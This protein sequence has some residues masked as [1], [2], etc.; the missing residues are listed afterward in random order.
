[1]GLR[2]AGGALGE[3]GLKNGARVAPGDERPVVAAGHP[4][5]QKVDRGIE[6]DGGCPR[7]DERA[8]ARIDEGAAAG[9][10]H[11]ARAGHQAGYHAALAVAEMRLAEAGKDIADGHAGGGFDFGVA[12]VER[13]AEPGGEAAADRGLAGPHQADEDDGPRA[14]ARRHA[15]GDAGRLVGAGRG[16]FHSVHARRYRGAM[17]ALTN[18]RGAGLFLAMALAAGQVPA[19]AQ[20]A[21]APKSL[22]PDD[23]DEAPT[24]ILPP[25]AAGIDQGPGVPQAPGFQ[26]LPVPAEPVEPDE[27][28]EPPPTDPFAE[29][30]GPTGQPQGAGLLDA[31][32]GGFGPD[33]FAGSDS[34]FLVTLLERIER[35]LAS[36]WAQILVQRALA[37]VAVP[38]GPHHPSDWLAARA[39]AL[40]A[41][42]AATDAHRMVARVAIDQ[43]T[44]RL[45]GAAAQAALAA[46]D[47]MALCPL[48]PT[49]RLALDT[50][51]WSLMDAMCLAI[52]GDEVG[53]TILFDR[54]RRQQG[55]DPFDIGLA[56][57][58][59]STAGAGRRGS[60][61]EWSD[62]Q[63]L[64]AFRIGLASAAGLDLPDAALGGA[65]RAQRAWL[66]RIPTVSVARRAAMAPMAAATG[67]FS[68]A[69][70]NRLLAAEVATLAAAEAPRSPGG[71]LRTAHADGD[72][73]QRIAAMRALWARGEGDPDLGYGWR[74][75]TAPAAARLAPSAAL[76]ADAADI[77]ASLNAA[78]YAASV[79]GWWQ[80]LAEA[81]GDAR[82]RLWG[83]AVAVAPA[84]PVSR[85]W[86]DRWAKEA[87][88]RRAALLSAG[89]LGLGRGAVGEAPTPIDNAWTR[90]LD[91]A[92]AGRR[93]GEVILLVAAGMQGRMADLPP[94][95]L[96]RIAA[97]L[98]AV[99]R[100]AEARL[101]VAEAIARS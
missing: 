92:L 14:P 83:H 59:A 10:Q 37:S 36:R 22:L 85:E 90:A 24:V 41:L 101:L 70:I 84:V 75:A 87:G 4:L 7:D 27:E 93:T 56:E 8:R 3:K 53:S 94:D 55:I 44:D 69:E 1:M 35:P 20:E 30:A 82:A 60:N 91:R 50:P 67:A 77:V 29:L 58:M 54:L 81:D 18:A 47:P 39:T 97:A 45:Y 34:R 49:A 19:V 80:A 23:F 68:A 74:V 66:A 25:G 61:P 43:Y 32:T 38:P 2:V 40:V 31:A 51:F 52:L 28:P 98:L 12:V 76:Q 88:P 46:G 26:P 65:S 89:L 96:R 99:G 73:G 62:M 33:L 100:E 21:G 78:G 16:G 15:A 63:G 57:R 6:P 9:S 5:D 86:Y 48:S 11:S 42:G 17:R 72:V 64:T 95:Y 13:P 71:Q 79:P